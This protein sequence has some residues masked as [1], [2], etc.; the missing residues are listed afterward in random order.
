MLGYVLLQTVLLFV[1]RTFFWNVNMTRVF[2][3]SNYECENMGTPAVIAMLL[4][5]LAAILI[6]LF[7]FF[8]GITRF[9]EDLSGKQAVLELLTPI[10]SW[11]K[12]AAKLATVLTSAIVGLSC[13]AVSVTAFILISS[14]FDKKVLDIFR[15]ALQK[16]F[17]SPGLLL[18]DILYIIFCFASLYMIVYFCI[19]FSK[20]FSHKSK[21][22]VLIGMLMFVTVITILG[23]LNELMLQFP[24]IRFNLLG[25]DSLSSVLVSVLVL[26]GSLRGTAWLMDHKIEY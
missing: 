11:K 18:L 23:F 26:F 1:A 13:S 15:S 10:A 12:L 5:F 25:E 9:N 4:F 3:E 20:M 19:A 7:P 17:A 14:R 8:E 22:A 2:T 24:I 21:A 16:A 6:G